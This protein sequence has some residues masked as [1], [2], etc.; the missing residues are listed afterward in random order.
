M[1]PLRTR[2]A[3]LTAFSSRSPPP[4]PGAPGS[5]SPARCVKRNGSVL[6]NTST[7][8]S[9]SLRRSGIS[10][11]LPARA[12]AR[13]QQLVVGRAVGPEPGPVEAAELRRQ[14]G[15]RIDEAHLGQLARRQVIAGE[16]VAD[17]VLRVVQRSVR[18]HR[19][20]R[21][22]SARGS[23]ARAAAASEPGAQ[24]LQL[25]LLRLAQQRVVAA[26]LLG[27]LREARLQQRGS[28]IPARAGGFGEHASVAGP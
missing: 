25:A 27:E 23:A 14:G 4:A 19:A 7:P 15:Q 9:C 3:R 24:Q 8:S 6:E 22:P 13:A 16:Q 1:R 10:A 18:P 12:A 20:G 26:D 21:R 28:R 5:R 11:R 17:L 2:R